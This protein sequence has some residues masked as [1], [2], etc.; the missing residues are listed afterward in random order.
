MKLDIELDRKLDSSSTTHPSNSSWRFGRVGG[1]DGQGYA[2]TECRAVDA[3]HCSINS[4]FTNMSMSMNK[5]NS[6]SIPFTTSMSMNS[7]R[8]MIATSNHSSKSRTMT[9]ATPSRPHRHPTH[10]SNSRPHRHT[11]GNGNSHG[12]RGDHGNDRTPS[13]GN[14][15]THGHTHGKIGDFGCAVSYQ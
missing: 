1:W 11:Q 4:H 10:N 14:Y 6:S 13:N 3:A 2:A 5:I 9:M 15:R 7:R 8:R 12:N